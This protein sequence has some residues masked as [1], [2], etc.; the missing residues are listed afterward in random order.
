[1]GRETPHCPGSETWAGTQFSHAPCPG[2]GRYIL[3]R[4]TDGQIRN[5]RFKGTPD[6]LVAAQN[7]EYIRSAPPFLPAQDST[8]GQVTTPATLLDRLL[9]MDHVGDVYVTVK[10][11]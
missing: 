8:Q 4:K 9:K 5:H 10:L 1:M 7:R 6:A 3:I 11:Q 2:C